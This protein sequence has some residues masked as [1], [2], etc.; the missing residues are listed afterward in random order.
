MSLT[1]DFIRKLGDLK[2]GERSLLRR[3]L[4]KPL[5]ASLPG[6][7]LFTGL[8]WPLRE[9]SQNAPSRET[10][11]LAAKLFC[12]RPIPHKRRKGKEDTEF[13]LATLLGCLEPRQSTNENGHKRFRD[14]FDAL[15]CASLAEIE[16][17]LDC[18]LGEIRRAVDQGKVS[19]LDWAQLLDDLWEWER[20]EKRWLNEDD[21]EAEVRDIRDE[22][23][24]QYLDAAQP[25]G[26]AANETNQATE[27]KETEKANAD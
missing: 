14:R 8:W 12:A 11:W 13:R 16:P 22:W 7:D 27:T 17:H 4:G 1:E 20:F 9:K 6:F 3:H 15:L 5:H 23:A 10:S 19:G 18:A 2:D 21:R 25:L 24:K 26:A